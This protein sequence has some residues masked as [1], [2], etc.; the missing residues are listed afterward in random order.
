MFFLKLLLLSVIGGFIGW[1]TN[2][3]AIRLLFRPL[4]PIRLP[5]GI[6][7]QGVLPARKKELAVTIGNVI[8]KQ[9][10]KPEE[11]LINLVQDKDIDYLKETI[12][13]NVVNILKEK[14]PS[15]LHSFTDK[16]IK[17]HLESFMDKEG[18][19]YIRDMLNKM[20]SN[21]TEKLCISKTVIE[22]IEALDLVSFEKIVLSVVNKELRFIE[23][24]GALLGFIIGMLQGF[25]L[26]VL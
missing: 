9:L 13:D 3:I 2:L 14:L 23:Y 26:L 1:F 16:T 12:V 6:K 17:K 5:F 15:F 24:L 19:R 21:G 20:I 22:K 10:V 7:I 8:E 25:I 4:N 11:V 18:D